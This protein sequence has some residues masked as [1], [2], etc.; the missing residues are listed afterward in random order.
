MRPLP[1]LRQAYTRVMDTRRI[2]PILRR[3]RLL[4]RLPA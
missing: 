2:A 1:P 3:A 4:N